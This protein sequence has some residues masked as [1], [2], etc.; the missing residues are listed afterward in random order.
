MI[1][2]EWDTELRRPAVEST[3]LHVSG[4]TCDGGPSPFNGESIARTFAEKARLIEGVCEV[5]LTSM[6]RGLL[7]TVLADDRDMERDLHLHAL[8]ADIAAD[9]DGEWELQTRVFSEEHAEDAGTLL[10]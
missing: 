5:R 10:P 6:D 8:F 2:I 7:V 1:P 4:G 9:L 3:A